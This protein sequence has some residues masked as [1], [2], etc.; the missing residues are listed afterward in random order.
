MLPSKERNQPSAS[1]NGICCNASTR[2][3]DKQDQNHP[4]PTSTVCFALFC[5]VHMSCANRS[6]LQHTEWILHPSLCQVSC[7]Y[8]ARHALLPSDCLSVIMQGFDIRRQIALMPFQSLLNFVTQ[9]LHFKMQP[10]KSLTSTKRAVSCKLDG[11]PW[12]TSRRME[13]ADR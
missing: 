10:A 3:E 11:V 7:S 4:K 5:F 12:S 9:Q 1:C 13:C 8:Q 2:I 6:F